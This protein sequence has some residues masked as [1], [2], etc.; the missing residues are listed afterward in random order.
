MILQLLRYYFFSLF[1]FLFAYTSNA[2][3]FGYYQS[4][5]IQMNWDTASD[6]QT[7]DT[8]SASWV[9]ATSPPDSSCSVI[10]IQ[11]GHIVLVSATLIADQVILEG[12][13]KNTGN[14]LMISNGPGDDLLLLP[15]GKI[16]NEKNA[17]IINRGKLIMKDSIVNH[18]TAAFINEG[19]LINEQAYFKNSGKLIN[20]ENSTLISSGD[21]PT[22]GMIIF[23]N[24]SLYQHL[25]PSSQTLSG[26]IP[27]A[28]WKVGSTCEI[29]ACGDAFQPGALNQTFH[30][31]IW[32]NS[33]QPHDFNLIANPNQV[34]GN[35][36]IRN[37]NQKKLAY[38]G[39]AKGDLVITDS[40]K[41]TGGFFILTNGITPTFIST[42]NYFQN[43]GVLD[44]S[45]SSAVCSLLVSQDFTH[46]NGQ[47]QCS[48]SSTSSCISMKG[49]S[50]SLIQST[51]FKQGDPISFF[52]NKESVTGT[53]IIPEKRSFILQEG[54]SFVLT[55]NNTVSTDLKINGILDLYSASWSL[56]KGLS[57]VYGSM[58]N[59]TAL[60][61]SLNSSSNN[62][63]FE[64]GSF[65]I[66]AGDG[67]EVVSALW[68]NSSTVQVSGIKQAQQLGNGD[69][70]FGN[71][72]WN[73]ADQHQPC[74]FGETGFG[75]LG[76]YTLESTGSSSLRF[77]DCDF[78]I[79]G[80]LLLHND[81][82]L[83]LS[84]GPGLFTPELRSIEIQGN[85]SVQQQ[86]F[87]QVGYPGTGNSVTGSD[88]FRIY[89]L[90]IKGN[91]SYRSSNPLISYHQLS[92]KNGEHSESYKL[93]FRFN[94]NRIQHYTMPPQ[95]TDLIEVQP[96]EYICNNACSLFISGKGT[97]LIPQ[98]F[99]V[100]AH[101]ILVEETDTLTIAKEDI[102]IQQ[103]SLSAPAGKVQPSSCYVYGVL[104]MGMNTLKETTSNDK[105]IFQLMKGATLKT[106]HP[107]GIAK[108]GN[109]GCILNS[110]PRLFDEGSNY[111]YSG[112]LPQFTG[113]GLPS[114]I[115]GSLKIDNTVSNLTG[116]VLL[117]QSLILSGMLYL[118]KGKLITTP[119]SPLLVTATGVISPEGGKNDSFVDGVLSKTGLSSDS[120]FTFPLGNKGKWA[121]LGIVPLTTSKTDTFSVSYA[122]VN[123]GIQNSIAHDSTLHH[124]SSK[125]HWTVSKT[126]VSGEASV[127]LHWESGNFSSIYSI[128]PEDL[129]LA[130]ADT[131]GMKCKWKSETTDF[132]IT[133]SLANGTI[134]ARSTLH[135]KDLYTFGSGS[136]INPLPVQLLSF[137]GFSTSDGNSLNWV[138]ASEKENDHF[139][140]QRSS[141]GSQFLT[142]GIVKGHGNSSN[143]ISYHFLDSLASNTIFYYR[144][145]QVDMDGKY[146]HSPV[147]R[148]ENN[149][150][151]D[152]E[153][154][155][156]P[157]PSSNE[158][159]HLLA[160]KD[161]KSFCIYNMLGTRL[162]NE[163][164]D[165]EN[166]EY[167]FSP[168]ANGIYFMQAI[169]MNGMV[170][171]KKIIKN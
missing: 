159:I 110:G 41:I 71:I 112:Y 58:I 167:I 149:S 166:K 144:L 160:G 40:F 114:N 19:F 10:H 24:K 121:R 131:I 42:K 21:F 90:R 39:S 107:Q 124:I 120:E 57:N 171:T 118:H 145:K 61:V 111:V 38:K 74:I 109:T 60:P 1:F 154:I 126:G 104:D 7:W 106:A 164:A 100:K 83:Q 44:M 47:I 168:A 5:A 82:R 79:Q 134:Q 8:A 155:I 138:T 130:H 77:P 115:S 87:L 53:C 18:S 103:F 140:I 46:I 136:S 88:P 59:H 2:Q 22:G 153:I 122:M 14:S 31:F 52:I 70:H 37:T 156:F 34:N 17:S 141:D 85:L 123:P 116:G 135:E 48:G 6:W 161:I 16:F 128:K 95:Q 49:T 12:T 67:G 125:E 132:S 45:A 97:H 98:L 32:N 169:T 66:H 68:D 56:T 73:A 133:G 152:A 163:I 137:T 63:H 35:F 62:L 65:Y 139:I 36:E 91:F 64:S 80:D 150:N 89:E 96:T 94:G 25:F 146:T 170:I 72:F 102:H 162:M 93:S 15:G 78:G 75:V 101:H 151:E 127:K 86:A 23:E 26:T 129:K 54:S 9:T 108:T 29:L 147:I 13:L 105:N 81:S 76:T 30:H 117:S 51:G 4:N 143:L 158:A 43:A 113:N 142:R 69:Q 165:D 3:S 20:T 84:A 27:S 92:D 99:N 33:T 157:N 50:P 11:K 55:D 28:D 148:I 119:S